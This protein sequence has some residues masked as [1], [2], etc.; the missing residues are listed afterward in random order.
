MEII[1]KEDGDRTILALVG[2]LDTNTSVQLEDCANE[3]FSAGKNHILVDMDECEFVSSAG[4]RIIVAM[5]KHV[6]SNGSLAF[7]NVKTEVMDV[8]DMT[9]FSKL[10][11]FE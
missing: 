4:L 7:C 10:L 1:K 2:R 11:T 8:F 9:G 3:L 5:Q 6:M